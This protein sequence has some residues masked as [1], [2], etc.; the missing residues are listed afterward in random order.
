MVSVSISHN[1][2]ALCVF[3]AYSYHSCGGPLQPVGFPAD[4]LGGAG[5]ARGARA[6]AALPHGEVV[7]A[8]AL[9]LAGPNRHAYTG[10]KGCVK[11]WDITNPGSPAALEPLS[12]LDCLVSTTRHDYRKHSVVK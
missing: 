12:Q 9:A 4:A 1:I 8:V 5:V 3:S 6:V 7:C 11:L 10:G 2:G